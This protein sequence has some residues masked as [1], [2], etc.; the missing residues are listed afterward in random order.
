M[1]SRGLTT[2]WQGKEPWDPQKHQAMK[3]DDRDISTLS[4][5]IGWNPKGAPSSCFP[6]QCTGHIF[7][8]CSQL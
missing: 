6:D 2:I 8:G 4:L 1:V 5:L 3:L 7:K